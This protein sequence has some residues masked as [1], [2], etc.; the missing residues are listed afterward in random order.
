MIITEDM[1]NAKST[2][3]L[4][5]LLFDYAHR[6]MLT[7]ASADELLIEVL[8]K[9]ERLNVNSRWLQ[10]FIKRWNEVQAEEDFEAA[11]I[12]RGEK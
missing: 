3:D 2:D 1:L 12:A 5:D 9:I 11:I 4:S 7:Y 8:G 10:G 6:N